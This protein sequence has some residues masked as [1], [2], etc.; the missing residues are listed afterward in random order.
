MVKERVVFWVG[1]GQAQPVVGV[2]PPA[3][4]PQS[5]TGGGGGGGGMGAGGGTGNVIQPAPGN[6]PAPNPS[7]SGSG[8]N[9]FSGTSNSA[10]NNQV[11][12]WLGVAVASVIVA[13]VELLL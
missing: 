11:T 10:D 1:I 3:D 2:V 12:D 13:C 6:Q 8:G 9:P 5:P 4:L 7:G